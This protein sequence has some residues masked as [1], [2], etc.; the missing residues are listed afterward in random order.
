MYYFRMFK[1]IQQKRY[2]HHQEIQDKIT[3]L[4]LIQVLLIQQQ[5]MWYCF[6]SC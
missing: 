3:I 4:K 6:Y 1:L 5:Y 2:H